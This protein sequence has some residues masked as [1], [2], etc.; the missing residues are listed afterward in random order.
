MRPRSGAWR[1]GLSLYHFADGRFENALADA[2]EIDAPDVAHGFVIR[3]ISQVRLG[4]KS[5]A[6]KSIGR[7][8]ALAPRRASGGLADSAGGMCS[9]IWPAASRRL[10]VTPA[11]RR[12]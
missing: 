12:N 4:R 8:M 2:V 11:C 10:C 1:S 6:A 9:R 3:A 5:E 7:I